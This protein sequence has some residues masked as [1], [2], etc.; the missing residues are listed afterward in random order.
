MIYKAERRVL[1]IKMLQIY[2]NQS[3]KS[4]LRIRIKRNQ[5]K[6]QTASL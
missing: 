3:S 6:F 1:Q 4:D 2:G 5:I